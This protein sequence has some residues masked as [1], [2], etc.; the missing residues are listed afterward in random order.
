MLAAHL[1]RSEIMRQPIAWLA[2][3]CLVGIARAGGNAAP[4]SQAAPPAITSGWT[5][6]K[7]GVAEGTIEA[8]ARHATNANP[9]LLK[10]SMTKYAE[11]GKGRVGVKNS[12]VIAVKEGAT[13]EITFNGTKE[14]N[15]GYGVGLVFS[16]E[17]DDGKVLA[18]TTLPEIGR[19]GR[20]GRGRGGAPGAEGAPP[21]SP[22]RPYLVS[23]TA[24]GS[25][26]NAHLTIT[27]IEPIVVWLE[28]IAIVERAPA[29]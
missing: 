14:G 20:G 27:P 8:D 13:Y 26:A 9:H 25:A 11:P 29:K 5:L 12:N 16:L 3:A 19:G 2:L 28:N 24:R 15:T 7:E 23:L 6:L 4:A 18:R 22:F 17:T 10:I 21:A 1:R